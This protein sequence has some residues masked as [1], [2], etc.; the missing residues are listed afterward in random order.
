MA[1]DD[2]LSKPLT[3]LG[4]VPSLHCPLCDHGKII[5]DEKSVE[6]SFDPKW[7]GADEYMDPDEY[8]AT[9]WFRCGLRCS[10][11]KLVGYAIGAFSQSVEA[12]YNFPDRQFTTTFKYRVRAM[13][14]SPLLFRPPGAIPD[15]V[16][17]PLADAFALFWADPSASANRCRVAVERM[18]DVLK[19]PKVSKAA[20]K[21]R[22]LQ[23]HQRLE[24]YKSM[25]AKLSEVLLAAKWI[26]NEASHD[27]LGETDAIDTFKILEHVLIELFD[28][29]KHQVAALV[30]KINR[31]KRPLSKSR[32]K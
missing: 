19:V 29:T 4:K 28:D 5:M 13:Q 9:G 24:L 26:G 32:K 2:A 27:T 23:L 17:Q 8:E 25:N 10:S 6:H 15:V 11:C 30:K 22:R 21:R 3:D 18:L 16:A 12:Y 20:T 14:P 7:D 1:I 31:R